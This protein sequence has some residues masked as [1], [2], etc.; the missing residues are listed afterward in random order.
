MRRTLLLALVLLIPPEVTAVVTRL[1]AYPRRFAVVVPGG[2]YRGGYP[3]AAQIRGL[4]GRERVRTIVS[5]TGRTEKPAEREMLAAAAELHLRVLRFPMPGN[6]CVDDWS[7]LDR[8]A[9]ALSRRSD[10]PIYFHCQAGKQRS[11]AV[12][13]AYRMR[14]CG[15][16]LRQALEE[17]E[18]RYG[19]DAAGKE[20]VLVEYLTR[21]AEHRGLSQPSAGEKT[22]A[23]NRHSAEIGRWSGPD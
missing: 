20:R 2:L 3:S 1:R 11:N 22:P 19:L 13:A 8:A 14:H 23:T 17:L 4:A 7:V 5:L 6:G 9:D 15:Y 21:Y 10:W 16:S 12:L 18:R